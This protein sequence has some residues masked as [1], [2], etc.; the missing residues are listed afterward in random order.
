[1]SLD[2]SI[3][4]GKEHRKPYYGSKAFDPSCRTKRCPFCRSNKTYKIRKNQIRQKQLQQEGSLKDLLP[5]D[6][7]QQ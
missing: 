2:K 3:K 5:E 1:M 7:L 6:F 4:S